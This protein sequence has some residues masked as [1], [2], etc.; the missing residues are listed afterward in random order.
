MPE[1]LLAV[2]YPKPVIQVAGIVDA[3]EARMLV[4]LGIRCLGFPLRLAVHREDLSESEAARIIRNLPEDVLGVLITY[5]SPWREVLE[6][7][8]FLGVRAVQ[9]HGDTPPEDIRRLKAARP[10]L[11]VIKS[12][13]IRPGMGPEDVEHDLACLIPYV[14]ALITDTFDPETGA[15]GATGKTHDWSISRTIVQRSS[16][17]VILAGGLHPENVADA[18]RQVRP[19]GVDAHTGLEDPSGRKDPRKVA[20]FLKRAKAAFAETAIGACGRD[21]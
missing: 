18:V 13:V 11:M 10:D 4:G 16:K 1:S 6:L 21:G 15:C 20:E 12:I 3:D 17:P 5:A 7:C 9:L 19:Y 8:S 2:T 14:D